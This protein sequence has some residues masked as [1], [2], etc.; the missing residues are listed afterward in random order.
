M[1]DV[2]TG[3]SLHVTVQ[4]DN[5]GSEKVIFSILVLNIKQKISYF[6]HR[7][8]VILTPFVFSLMYTMA[9]IITYLFFIKHN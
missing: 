7:Y 9:E 2:K 1:P 6:C 4:R 8:I 3:K 5:K